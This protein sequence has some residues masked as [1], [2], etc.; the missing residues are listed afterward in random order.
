MTAVISGQPLSSHYSPESRT[1]NDLAWERH[2][3]Y[4]QQQHMEEALAERKRMEMQVCQEQQGLQQGMQQGMQQGPQQGGLSPPE[5]NFAAWTGSLNRVPSSSLSPN[6]AKALGLSRSRS[7]CSIFGDWG[8]N[9]SEKHL[10]RGSTRVKSKASDGKGLSASFRHMRKNESKDLETANVG[11]DG[12]VTKDLN[13]LQPVSVPKTAAPLARKSTLKSIAP[14]IRSLARRCSSKFGS[15]PYS[16]AGT[17]SDPIVEFPDKKSK[18]NDFNTPQILVSEESKIQ[19]S[20]QTAQDMASAAKRNLPATLVTTTFQLLGTKP[21]R[22]SVHRKV[23]L[24]RSK[25]M[26]HSS[27]PTLKADELITKHS[28]SATDDPSTILQTQSSPDSPRSSL[29]LANGRGLDLPMVNSR[30]QL[31]DLFIQ[32]VER[33][34]D[35]LG[36]SLPTNESVLDHASELE[37]EN[38]I[39]RQ[40]IEILAMGRKERISARTGQAIGIHPES[41]LSTIPLSPLA[42]EAQEIPPIDP[43]EALNEEVDPCERIAFML[44]PKSRYEFQPLVAV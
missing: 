37:Q 43:V 3:Y 22:A 30:P 11:D 39:R 20:Q 12:N 15:R 35:E 29:R 24:Y 5:P 8:A 1:A 26:T 2:C 6:T 27:K 13:V 44:V 40:I 38:E 17:S 41:K 18:A 28:R 23:T 32:D 25:T 21:E 14:S 4:Q 10:S 16:I 36:K 42:L 7:L 19:D 34:A 9:S 31:N 33:S